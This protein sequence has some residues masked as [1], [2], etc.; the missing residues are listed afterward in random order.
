MKKLCLRFALGA[1]ALVLVLGIGCS[2]K[3][4]WSVPGVVLESVFTT[5]PPRIDGK[6]LDREWFSAPELMVAVG[7]NNGNGGGSFYVRIKSV[8]TAYDTVYFLLQ[9]AD[10][11]ESAYPDRL[12]YCGEPWRER[13]CASDLGLVQSSSWTRRPWEIENED[14]A[15]FMF[16]ITPASDA[17]GTFASRG[18][19]VACHGNM[20][21]TAGKLDVWYWMAVRTNQVSRCDDMRADSAGLAGDTGDG[22][23]RIN[24]RDP[25]FV[26]KYLAQG[27]N[28]GL[29]PAKCIYD[30][31]IFGRG[32]NQC[33]T[34]NP[35]SGL[36]WGDTLNPEGFDY[37]PAY[38][39]KW[40]T[41]SRGDIVAKG[42]W[43][44]GRWTVEIK[45]AM[46]PAGHESE[47]VFFYPARTYNFAV[48]IM[49][50][51]REIHSGSDPLVLKFR[52]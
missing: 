33:D 40:P 47:D 37:V 11:E 43:D 6:A 20:H 25:T 42:F 19:S 51:S 16:E 26:P 49:N 21:P 31:G 12:I 13:S 3:S 30:P 39:V 14:R 4:T 34:I 17:S 2:E 44:D 15:A 38:V 22:T 29:S 1:I 27:D 8:Y 35:Y 18:C 23:W 32:F 46:R 50:G 24:W 7:D 10:A 52:Q 45:R 48:A 5:E 9:W 28:G 36:A 41:G